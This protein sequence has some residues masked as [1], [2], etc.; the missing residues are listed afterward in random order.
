[1]RTLDGDTVTLAPRGRVARMDG[2]PLVALV[3]LGF[4]S[5]NQYDGSQYRHPIVKIC[6]LEKATY[7]D[8]KTVI[9][10]NTYRRIMIRFQC[11]TG[12]KFDGQAIA[13]GFMSPRDGHVWSRC[14]GGE[15]SCDGMGDYQIDRL[16]KVTA[17]IR[18]ARDKYRDQDHRRRYTGCD[19]LDLILS[20]QFVGVEIRIKNPA[21]DTVRR[22]RR[23]PIGT[24]SDLRYETESLARSGLRYG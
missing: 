3:D 5:R 22:S 21:I 24:E 16:A 17:L 14:Y 10:P 15:I 9:E 19:L 11:D 7:N 20:L 13:R 4:G 12:R 18:R 2:A 8:G 23:P 6:T 1:M